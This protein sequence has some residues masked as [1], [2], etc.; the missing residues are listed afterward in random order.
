MANFVVLKKHGIIS[1]VYIFRYIYTVLLS[2][3][4]ECLGEGE[5]Y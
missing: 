5:W 1:F 2:P 3:A 4:A